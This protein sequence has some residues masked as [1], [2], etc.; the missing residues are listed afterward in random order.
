MMKDPFAKS[1]LSRLMRR[2]TNRLARDASA[3]LAGVE[4]S[5]ESFYRGLG[6]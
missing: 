5:P 6:C 1:K 3:A 4:M 2:P